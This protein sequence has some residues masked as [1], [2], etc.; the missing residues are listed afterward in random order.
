M[1]TE[2]RECSE[3][4][5]TNV[6]LITF[7]LRRHHWLSSKLTQLKTEMLTTVSSRHESNSERLKDAQPMPMNA[8]NSSSETT[9]M[10]EGILCKHSKTSRA[11]IELSLR[12][13]LR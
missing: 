3:G 6:A 5:R 1:E 11:S 8:R 9:K 13:K 7:R 2:D 10:F 12:L 4:L